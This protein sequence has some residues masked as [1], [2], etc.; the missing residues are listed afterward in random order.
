MSLSFHM[1]SVTLFSISHSSDNRPTAKD[2]AF[3]QH[4][5][6]GGPNQKVNI[7]LLCNVQTLLSSK[8]PQL[9]TQSNTHA[10]Q[11]TSKKLSALW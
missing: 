10:A 9:S 8:L 3:I 2:F 11:L 4:A 6:S 7:W 5:P 1:T